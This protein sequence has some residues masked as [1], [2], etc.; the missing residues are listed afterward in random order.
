MNGHNLTE[1]RFPT[2]KRT[3]AAT[4]VVAILFGMGTAVGDIGSCGQSVD[5]LDPNTFFIIKANIDCD[6]CSS[7]GF[8]GKTCDVACTGALPSAFPSG[9]RP[10]VHDGEVC[11]HA[12][13]YASCTEYAAYMRDVAPTAPSECQFCP[14]R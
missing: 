6:R 1:P 7:C 5:E 13:T 4:A 8:A 14:V 9:C 3:Y 12:L 10:L 11:L 2:K